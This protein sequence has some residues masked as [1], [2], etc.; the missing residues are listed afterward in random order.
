MSQLSPIF[1]HSG[2][3][4]SSTW[5]WSKIRALPDV[6][7][8]YEIFHERLASVDHDGVDRFNTE[9]WDSRHPHTAPYFR[10]YL[11]LIAP[12]GGV[13]GYRQRMA[14]LDFVADGGLQAG[15]DSDTRDY[16]G[17]LIGHAHAQG[18]RPV[19]TCGRTLG[20]VAG[21][22]RAFGGAHVL[23][24]RDL[25]RQWASYLRLGNDGVWYFHN[26]TLSVLAN[27]RFNDAFLA[28]LHDAHTQAELCRGDVTLLRFRSLGD[29]FR[30]FVGLHLYF[31]LAALPQVDLVLDV[32]AMAEDRAV[33]E[34]G[35]AGFAALTGIAPDLRDIR[36]EE[37]GADGLRLT[38]AEAAAL[39][40][41]ALEALDLGEDAREA[42][43]GA[44]LLRPVT[45]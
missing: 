15:L 29:Y 17:G 39:L 19:L 26:A 20:R 11:D 14:Y 43:W 4:V 34:A 41:D 7:A 18:R 2:F 38:A 24:L 33:L 6:T 36:A 32:S 23:L 8:Y 28:R 21:L 3:R 42:R 31:Y 45:G 44:E 1:I 9:C 13:R 30:A 25:S 12:G 40:R 22:R 37:A 5:L 16:V 27:G 35:M 10:E